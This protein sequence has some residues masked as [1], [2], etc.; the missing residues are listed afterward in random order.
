MALLVEKRFYTKYVVVV[1]CQRGGLTCAR[2]WVRPPPR[3]MKIPL[4]SQNSVIEKIC[5][6]P[7][8][9]LSISFCFSFYTNPSHTNHFRLRYIDHQAM[10]KEKKSVSQAANAKQVCPPCSLSSSRYSSPSWESSVLC[11]T[12]PSACS[13]PS[14]PCPCCP[15]SSAP[16]PVTPP[17]S[18]KDRRDSPV[19]RPAISTMLIR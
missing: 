13:S 6:K 14:A 4:E 15:S 12:S 11:G 8:R 16:P 19:P 5:S 17:H 9:L 1:Q 2:S 10:C 18:T 7:S 3:T